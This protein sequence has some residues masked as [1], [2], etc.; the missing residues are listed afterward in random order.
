MYPPALHSSGV[1]THKNANFICQNDVTSLFNIHTFLF[2]LLIEKYWLKE[3]HCIRLTSQTNGDRPIGIIP[4]RGTYR[5][6][7]HDNALKIKN[8]HFRFNVVKTKIPRI[9]QFACTT[10]PA[11]HSP[12]SHHRI[13]VHNVMNIF[14]SI[15]KWFAEKISNWIAMRSHS[16]HK[17]SECE[18]ESVR[19]L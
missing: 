11:L 4:G 5:R 7:L 2:H 13:G 8:V 9:I 3:L 14:N 19:K 16:H 1:P 18:Y 6:I 12:C 15:C 10:T 17:C